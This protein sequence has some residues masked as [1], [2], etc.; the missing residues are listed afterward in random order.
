MA[1]IRY[2]SSGHIHLIAEE[3]N[4]PPNPSM[5][6]PDVGSSSPNTTATDRHQYL[7]LCSASMSPL[8]VQRRTAPLDPQAA[9]LSLTARLLIVFFLRSSPA[10]FPTFLDSVPAS[11]DSIRFAAHL[12]R[13][14]LLTSLDSLP[15]H[16]HFANTTLF[17]PP[18]RKKPNTASSVVRSGRRR[19][20]RGRSRR[21]TTAGFLTSGT[22]SGRRCRHTR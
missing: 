17:T 3:C 20:S 5:I 13:V 7:L 18:T 14:A 15:K 2:H 6:P 21:A 9:L 10:S 12:T 16:T 4:E 8:L 11:L 1:L 22:S 19:W